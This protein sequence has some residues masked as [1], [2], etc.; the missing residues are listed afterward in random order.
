MHYIGIDLHKKS[1]TICLVDQQGQV[2]A[3][4]QLACQQPEQIVTWFKQWVP[5]QAVIEATASY[6]WLRLVCARESLGKED[7]ML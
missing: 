5:F 6:E 7:G 1:I 3:R 2:Q 4:R